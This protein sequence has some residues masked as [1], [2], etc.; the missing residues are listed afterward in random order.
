MNMKNAILT[1]TRAINKN[2]MRS[3]L[4]S[5]GIIIGVSSVIMMI[6]IG[7]S[8]RVAV[9]DKVTTFGTN[10]MS[11]YELK[12]PVSPQ[13]L[14]NLARLYFQVRYVT[15]IISRSDIVV[16]YQNKNMVT[17]ISGVNNDYFRIKDWQLRYGRYFTDLEISSHDKVAVIGNTVRTRLFGY[18]D[19]VG[20]III[21]NRI[22]FKVAGSLIEMGQMF[23]AR[24]VDN[25]LIL[26]YTTTQ[27]RLSRSRIFDE[28][29][30]ATH[31]EKMV[32]ETVVLLKK[33]FRTVLETPPGQKDDFKIKT[34]KEKLKMAEYISQTLSILL[35][36]IA[37]ISLIVGGVGIMNIM[38]VSV[39]ERTRE[40]GIRMSI[41]AKRKDIMMQFLIESFTL[42]SLGGIV[43]VGFG[44]SVYGLIVYFVDWPFIFS[45]ASIFLSF[46]F[47]G[48][49]GIFFGYYPA[50]KAAN[51][52]PIEALRFE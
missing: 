44:L 40:I 26:P 39:S 47:A 1:A 14:D 22:P 13:D 20:K 16:K 30:V 5:V 38:L 35:A 23:S 51:L 49:V 21:V 48:S 6:G 10:A 36:G 15:P 45:T 28:I 29:Y 46:F 4:T 37:S 12:K 32:D 33:Y 8:A 41:G 3:G 52:R 31:S 11:I 34:S 19:P 25:I 9:K 43:G 2:K 18:I 24:D 7:N 17:R 50:R 42:S 27:T